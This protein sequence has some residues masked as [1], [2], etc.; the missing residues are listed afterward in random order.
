MSL[1]NRLATENITGTEVERL[2]VISATL[3]LALQF[4]FIGRWSRKDGI[5][6]FPTPVLQTRRPFY[7]KEEGS[8]KDT[9]H[10]RGQTQALERSLFHVCEGLMALAKVWREIGKM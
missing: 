8:H 1:T 6:A 5:L 2:W 10:Q 7:H 3:Y 4:S 9:H